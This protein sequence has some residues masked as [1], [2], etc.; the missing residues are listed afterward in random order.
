M[1][2]LPLKKIRNFGGK[3]G[4]ELQALRCNTAG[5]VMAL[6]PGKLQQNFGERASWILYTLQGNSDEQ[7]QVRSLCS[8]LCGLQVPHMMMM[9]YNT[10]HVSTKGRI[11]DVVL[12]QIQQVLNSMCLCCK[13]AL[14]V[15]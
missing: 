2:D 3:L 15:Q 8:T 5:D 6:A 10:I 4:A 9:M 11:A 14:S 12:G 7:V 13:Q 1:R